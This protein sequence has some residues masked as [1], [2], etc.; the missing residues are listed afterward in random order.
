[1]FEN[2]QDEDAGY[3]MKRNTGKKF[4]KKTQ[5]YLEKIKQFQYNDEYDDTLEYDDKKKRRRN[6]DR[7]NNKNFKKVTMRMDED[8]IPGNDD[9]IED[10]DPSYTGK[11]R[12]HN[13]NNENRGGK[14]G[15]YRG[16]GRKGR[17]AKGAYDKYQNKKK[18]NR[19]YNQKQR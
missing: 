6:N 12:H 11:G 2:E 15:G 10:Q 4:D 9:E 13:Y 5:A 19:E 17:G 16:R 1:M 18:N 8:D 7:G 14:R 3:V